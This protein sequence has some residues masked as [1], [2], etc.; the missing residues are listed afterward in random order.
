M[1]AKLTASPELLTKEEAKALGL[2]RFF[3]GEPCKHGHVSERRVTSGECI[4]C[5]LAAAS[6]HK[7]SPK[8]EKSYH[9][10]KAKQMETGEWQIS[11]RNRHLKAT[12]GLSQ[13]DV[14]RMAADQNNACGI[15]GCHITSAY[16][17]DQNKTVH[18]DHSHATGQVRG[19]LCHHCNKAIGNFKE[20]ITTLRNAIAY[21][22]KHSGES[23]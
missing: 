8:W 11:L 3:T 18:V 17:G 2:V 21:L 15:C 7:K 23:N 5:N 1:T 12:Y 10:R 14:D 19:L 4:K 13:E 9:S 20:N 22:Q 16:T 6:K